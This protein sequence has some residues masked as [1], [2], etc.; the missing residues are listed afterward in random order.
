MPYSKIRK[1]LLYLI[2]VLVCTLQPWLE[3]LPLHFCFHTKL[4]INCTINFLW[5][6]HFDIYTCFGLSINGNYIL[7]KKFVCTL[8]GSFTFI[9]LSFFKSVFLQNSCY[10]NTV[11]DT[12][13]KQKPK[14]LRPTFSNFHK[15]IFST[16]NIEF[17]IMIFLFIMWWMGALIL[18][19]G[20]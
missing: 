17:I 4:R 6:T 1:N 5:Q 3:T 11:R 14:D 15:M 16:E 20:Y 2:I 18:N 10:S 7:R 12:F 9:C 13:L 19:S 8:Q